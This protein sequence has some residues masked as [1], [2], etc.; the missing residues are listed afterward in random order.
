MPVP[1]ISLQ[2]N[3]YAETRSPAG[4]W[5]SLGKNGRVTAPKP[6]EASIL[7]GR[8][9]TLPVTRRQPGGAVL[10]QETPRR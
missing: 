8:P 4:G 7:A 6:K 1:L 3:S 9:Y 10:W 2:K 5:T